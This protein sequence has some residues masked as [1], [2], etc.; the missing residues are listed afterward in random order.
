[1]LLHQTVMI[2]ILFFEKED[3]I[4]ARNQILEVLGMDEYEEPVSQIDELM[5]MAERTG[6]KKNV[7]F[8][9]TLRRYQVQLAILDDLEKSLQEEGSLVTKEYV[10]GRKNVYTNPAIV[11]Y[12]KTT[13]SANKT[14]AALF[15]IMERLEAKNKKTGSE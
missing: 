2:L 9:T 12:N 14:A 15:D 5:K 4:Y 13:D 6:A 7:L 3:E 10:K 1:M 11:Q 8:L